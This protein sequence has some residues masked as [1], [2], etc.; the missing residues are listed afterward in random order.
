VAGRGRMKVGGNVSRY[1]GNGVMESTMLNGKGPV[2]GSHNI[3][4]RAARVVYIN[5]KYEY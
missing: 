2:Q 3:V 4:E 1:N 5:Q